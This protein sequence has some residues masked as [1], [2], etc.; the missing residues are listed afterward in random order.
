MSKNVTF[1][2][3]VRDEQY[4][5]YSGDLIAGERVLSR[6]CSFLGGVMSGQVYVQWGFC[7]LTEQTASY[8]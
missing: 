1:Y 7:L 4:T 6:R 8:P 3:C 2:T 5:L